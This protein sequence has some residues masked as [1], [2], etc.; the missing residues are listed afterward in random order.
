MKPEYLLYPIITNQLMQIINYRTNYIL[1]D[2]LFVSILFILFFIVDI[3]KIKHK[4]SDLIDMYNYKSMNTLIFSKEDKMTTYKY[5]AIMYYISKNKNNTIYCLRE[6]SN[7]KWDDKECYD[8]EYMS[9]YMVEQSR[10][11]KLDENIMG[12]ISIEKKDKPNISRTNQIM[13]ELNIIKIYSKKYDLI[14]LQNWVNMR[15]IEFKEHLRQRSLNNQL[16]LTISQNKKDLVV[17]ANIWDSTITFENSYSQYIDEILPKINFFINNRKWY[18]EKGIPYNMGI[19]LYGEPGCGKTRFIKQLMNHTK[20]HGID[21]KLNDGL[22]FKYL[23]NIIYNEEI[24]E[25]Y[26][27]PQNK[28]IIIFEDI[29]AMGD[30][31]KE[32]KEKIESENKL[33]TYDKLNTYDK[34]NIYDVSNLSKSL[35]IKKIME[36]ENQLNNNLSYLLNI[37]DG[38]NECSGRIII[39]TTNNIDTLDKALIRPGRIDIKIKFS[40]LSRYDIYR[41]IKTF[42][43]IDINIEIV[44]ESIET[45]YTAAEVI[46]IFRTTDNF[47]DIKHLFIKN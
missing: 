9:E 5:R 45:K 24:D 27:I 44:L 10:E 40:K 7:F 33:D 14:Y 47:N 39:M 20:R 3:S 35:I 4:V 42:W 11:F 30:I 23:K 34:S 16:L 43:K 36:E 38:L 17:E 46:N 22:D 29:D 6:Y 8:K 18:E 28:R 19:L 25:S 31:V 21:I 13:I 41:M 26:I 1:L 15:V 2:I 12:C 37:L 32:R